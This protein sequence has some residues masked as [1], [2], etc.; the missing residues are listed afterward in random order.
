MLAINS[1]SF[2][3]YSFVIKL[4]NCVDIFAIFVDISVIFVDIF[5]IFVDISVIFVDIFA[6]FVD[7]SVIFVDISVIFVELL[8]SNSV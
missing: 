7:I 5:A 1:S 3:Y 2:R 6:I 4:D 8:S